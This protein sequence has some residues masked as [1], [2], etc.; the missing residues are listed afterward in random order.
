[1]ELLIAAGFPLDSRRAGGVIPIHIAA[2]IYCA[3]V[4][5]ALMKHGADVNALDDDGQG[6]L[7]YVKSGGFQTDEVIQCLLA[8]GAD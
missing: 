2:E 1:M 5:R 8:S 4:L 7:N 3:G 6:P